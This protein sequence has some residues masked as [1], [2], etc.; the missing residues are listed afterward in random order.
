[1]VKTLVLSNKASDP[2]FRENA[3]TDFFFAGSCLDVSGAQFSQLNI[4][5]ADTKTINKS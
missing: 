4:G 1:M 2:I 3:K 5:V